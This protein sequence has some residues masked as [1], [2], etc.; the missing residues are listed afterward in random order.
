MLAVLIFDSESNRKHG[1]PS[2]LRAYAA[3]PELSRRVESAIREAITAE[4]RGRGLAAGGST[5]AAHKPPKARP[6]RLDS[7]CGG[8]FDSP[9]KATAHTPHA[10]CALRLLNPHGRGR[11]IDVAGD[12]DRMPAR[13]TGRP[14]V[15]LREAERTTGEH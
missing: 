12:A 11:K 9:S 15:S 8:H 6:S 7:F 2:P 4:G 1:Q 3:C 5:L 10:R 14:H 13:A